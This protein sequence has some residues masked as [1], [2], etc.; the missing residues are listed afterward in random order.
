[1]P[2]PLDESPLTD[3]WLALRW[4]LHSLRG[5]LRGRVLLL[6]TLGLLVAEIDV[7]ILSY[8]VPSVKSVSV[9]SLAPEYVPGVSIKPSEL[10]RTGW[11][12]QTSYLR[13]FGQ[14]FADLLGEGLSPVLSTLVGLWRVAVWSLFGVAICRVTSRHLTRNE[15]PSGVTALRESL[16]HWGIQIAGPVVLLAA[17]G[18]LLAMLWC[19]GWV[20]SWPP[21]G[22]LMAL[23]WP[24][25]FLLGTLTALLAVTLV[26]GTPLMLASFAV[27]RPDPFDAVSSAFAYTTQ[28]PLRLIAYIF[29]AALVGVVA[30]AVLHLFLALAIWCTAPWLAGSDLFSGIDDLNPN[31]LTNFNR[32]V[33]QWWISAIGFL[34]LVFHA[35]Y[36]WSAATAIYLLMRREIDEKQVDE[37]FMPESSSGQRVGD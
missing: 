22:L 3:N 35:A 33:V 34:P 1:M 29:Q 2:A 8:F 6:A 30:G 4:M 18:L 12:G 36:F 24:L 31:G 37:I 28:R 5:T 25:I 9:S 17:T 15:L 23:G 20:A 19:L 11:Q 21:V 27:E 32:E 14:P 26:V 13:L 10:L 16:K 7:A